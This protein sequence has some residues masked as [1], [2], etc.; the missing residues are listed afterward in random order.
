MNTLKNQFK[1]EEEIIK[2]NLRKA[3]YPADEIETKLN[4]LKDSYARKDY[5]NEVIREITLALKK[6]PCAM[7]AWYIQEIISKVT[8][9]SPKYIQVI[10]NSRS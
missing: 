7:Q 3:G 2:E 5:R 10:S 9:L 4:I 6:R 1:E 8:G